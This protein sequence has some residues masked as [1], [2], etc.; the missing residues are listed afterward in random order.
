ML[1]TMANTF[2]VALLTE[3]QILKELDSEITELEIR[4]NSFCLDHIKL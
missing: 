3:F 2:L 1:T 4:V